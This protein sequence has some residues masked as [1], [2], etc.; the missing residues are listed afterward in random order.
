LGAIIT[1]ALP[2]LPA[3]AV[4]VLPFENLSADP[5]NGVFSLNGGSYEILNIWQ[6][7]G[8][9]SHHPDVGDVNTKAALN[10]TA[11]T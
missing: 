3:G 9:E 10:E 5:G 6:N 11:P 7:R 4:A 8:L 2:P 1:R